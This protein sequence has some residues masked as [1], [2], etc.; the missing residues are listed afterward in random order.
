LGI[1]WRSRQL[2]VSFI[3][4]YSSGLLCVLQDTGEIGIE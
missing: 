1:D 2:N 4:C 3:D